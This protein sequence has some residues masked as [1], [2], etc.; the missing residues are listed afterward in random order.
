MGIRWEQHR[1]IGG[2]P[3]EWPLRLAVAEVFE[4]DFES[5]VDD[6]G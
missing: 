4:K 5:E 3:D 2:T 1:D 6:L